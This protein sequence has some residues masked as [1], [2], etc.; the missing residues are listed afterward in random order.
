MLAGVP[1]WRPYGDAA[2]GSAPGGAPTY[3]IP[4][5]S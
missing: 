4:I 5:Q 2:L 1:L 3:A